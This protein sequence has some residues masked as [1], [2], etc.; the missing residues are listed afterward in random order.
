MLQNIKFIKKSDSLLSDQE[1]QKQR[2]S[3]NNG[4]KEKGEKIKKR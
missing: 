4:E 3:R 1:Y 2:A